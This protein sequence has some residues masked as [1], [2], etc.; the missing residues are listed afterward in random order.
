[1]DYRAYLLDDDG[2]SLAFTSW[3]ALTTKRRNR[4]RPRCSTGAI[5]KCGTVNGALPS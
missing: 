2:T 5:W 1:M 3:I 4:K